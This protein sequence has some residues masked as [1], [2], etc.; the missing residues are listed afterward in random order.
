MRQGVGGSRGLPMRSYTAEDVLAAATAA[1]AN[2]ELA[3][4]MA[5]AAMAEG[6]GDL[7]A[8]GDYDLQGTAHS[9]G[10]YQINDINAVPRLV[11]GDLTAATEWMYAHEFART[12][13]TACED[14]YA[15]EPLARFVYMASER[16]EGWRGPG[17]P[18]LG[19]PAAEHFAA[20][21]RLLQEG[22]VTDL[23]HAYLD[24]IRRHFGTPY[25]F[26]AKGPRVFDCSGLLTWCA[27]EV[28]LAL[29]DPM[30]TSADGLKDHCDPVPLAAVKPGDLYL[31]SQTYGAGGPHYATHCGAALGDGQYMLDDHG[32]P[33]PGCGQTNVTAPYWDAHLMGA[34][35]PR[36]FGA[37]EEDHD[38]NNADLINLLG[39]IQGDWCEA[40]AAAV[41]AA[42]TEE[43]PTARNDLLN[44]A[45]AAL[46]TIRRGG[47][48]SDG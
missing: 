14:G 48:P 10:P 2:A 11:R 30:M 36:G 27:Q 28:G 31:F 22:L 19:S 35:R 42:Q 8:A 9:F 44:A 34:W 17:N 33:W 41:R 15:G 23:R 40:A 3:A 38:V 24:E 45:L 12:Y 47:P 25:V 18:G 21:W 13:A 39:N 4:I 43:D 46:A 20:Q 37:D 6:G 5:A 29:G 32:D 1:G 7:D 16:P 26:G